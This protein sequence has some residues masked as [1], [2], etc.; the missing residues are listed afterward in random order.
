MLQL[1]TTLFPALAATIRRP[2]GR[3][4]DLLS[5]LSLLRRATG[6]DVHE[7]DVAVP[8]FLGGPVIFP[9]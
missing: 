5:R 6:N 4:E 7:V 8:Y 9:K 2:R 1:R 3:R